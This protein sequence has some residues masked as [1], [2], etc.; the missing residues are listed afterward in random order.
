M[1]GQVLKLSYKDGGSEVLVGTDVPVVTFGPGDASLLKPGATVL[2]S[3]QKAPD[4][5]LTAAR[6]VAEKDGVKPPM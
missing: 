4:D 3:A 5:S 6:V 2:V 1:G